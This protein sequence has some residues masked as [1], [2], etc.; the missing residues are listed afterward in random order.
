MNIVAVQPD[1]AWED[2]EAN[3]RTVEQMLAGDT[4]EP[5]SL[6]VLPEMFATGFSM[7]VDQI[8]EGESSPTEAFLDNLA[9]RYRSTIIGGLVRRAS[10]G[11]GLNEAVVVGPGGERLTRYAKLHPFSFAGETEH[12]APGGFIALFQW[13]D[14]TVAPFICY[15]L[16]FPEIFRE[17]VQRGADLFAVIACWPNLRE[18]HWMA[19]L[20]A[21][22]IENQ[23]WVVGVNRCGS[24]P[25]LTYS[26]HSQ[27]I[28]PK[29]NVIVDADMEQ[30]LI[31][32]MPDHAA[33]VEYRREF[34]V[35]EDI[36]A[37]YRSKG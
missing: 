35:L 11:R 34:P 26:G 30:K 19:L 15:D 7:Q 36:R 14:F 5:D 21:R 37:E 4:I 23:A 2:K 1:I 6:I 29:G 25:K 28:D 32:A 18:R 20:R 8:A 17:A 9:R 16:R 24:D 3:Y 27:I 22:A 31:Q 10:D 12:Y 33:L 13:G